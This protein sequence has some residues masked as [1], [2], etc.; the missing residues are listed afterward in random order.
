MKTIKGEI[1]MKT[2]RLYSIGLVII[3]AF[4]FSQQTFAQDYGFYNQMFSNMLSNRIWDSIYEQSSPGYAEAKKKLSDS[5]SKSSAQTSPSPVTPGQMNRAVQ[6]KSTG[7]RLMTQ[8]FADGLGDKYKKDKAV[9]KE[10]LTAILDRY[11]TEAA[12]KGYS[13]DLALALASYIALNRRAYHGAREKSILPFE[14]NIGLRDTIAEY[15]AQNGAFNKMT[16]RQRQEM[17]EALVMVGVLTHGLYEAAQEKKDTET[18][19]EIKQMA[20]GNLKSIG[21]KP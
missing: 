1:E 8:S 13:N 3:I 21:I 11:D 17:Y 19:K 6:F 4:T 7:T 16:D 20:K 15:A 18:L 12:A 2:L 14:Q 5:K 9:M 10:M